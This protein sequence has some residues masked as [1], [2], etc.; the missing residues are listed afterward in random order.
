MSWK[1]LTCAKSPTLAQPQLKVDPLAGLAEPAGRWAGMAGLAGL[2][3]G[4][5]AQA[6][7]PMDG[8]GKYRLPGAR[9]AH[10]VNKNHCSG[11]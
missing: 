8:Y 10:K 3:A 1:L 6:E 4:W 2:A 11:Q 9:P 5:A 7:V